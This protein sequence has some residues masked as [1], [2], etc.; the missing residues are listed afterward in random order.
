MRGLQAARGTAIADQEGQTAQSARKYWV[1]AAVIGVFGLVLDQSLKAL[2]IARLDP[3]DPV[4]LFSGLV[5]LRLIRN[6]GAAFSMGENFTVVLT[7]VAIV[8][9]IAVSAWGVPKVR[10]YGWALTMGFL[11]A[12]ISGNLF[13]RLFREPGPFQGH[14]V[15]F[16]QLP[17][18]AIFNVA[19]IFITAA[20]VLVVWLSMVSQVGLDGA[21]LSQSSKRAE[22]NKG[23]PGGSADE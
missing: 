23:E 7:V 8:A 20:A 3:Q 4:E 14:V 22:L 19:D 17:Y 1:L 2:A 5:T 11:L 10:H 9:L 6:P 18:F 12:G 15:D 16:I 13:D 21:R